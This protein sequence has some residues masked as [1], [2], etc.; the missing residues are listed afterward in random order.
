MNR[1]IIGLGAF[2]SAIAIGAIASGIWWTETTRVEIQIASVQPS[3][4]VET[5]GIAP[6]TDEFQAEFFDIPEDY[7]GS[8]PDYNV[9]L[10]DFWASEAEL[11]ME[12]DVYAKPGE[13]WLTLLEGT[14]G[15]FSLKS[16]KVKLNK[17]V[18]AGGFFEGTEVSFSTGPVKTF[19]VRAIGGLRPGAVKT[20]YNAPV[21]IS[22][23]ANSDRMKHG[24]RR[25]FQLGSKNYL[26]RV[27][28]GITVDGHKKALLILSDGH[29]EQIIDRSHIWDGMESHLGTLLWAGD[30]NGDGKL[31]LYLDR[32]YDEEKSGTGLFLSPLDESENL[33]DL[34]ALFAHSGC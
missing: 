33:V 14:D 28:T 4:V 8:Y 34:A 20:V 9:D 17:K 10:M 32:Y 6:D 18:N 30:L 23:P 7:D 24:F 15:S 25:E 2:L 5:I 11:F 19:A 16:A 31:D 29:R 1:H 13:K 27:S 22:D 3:A 12:E 26:L 21:E